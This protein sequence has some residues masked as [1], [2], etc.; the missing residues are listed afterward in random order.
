MADKPAP[1]EPGAVVIAAAVLTL[2]AR[3]RAQYRQWL[4]R[5]TDYT[6]ASFCRPNKS[7]ASRRSE[8]RASNASARRRMVNPEGTDRERPLHTKLMVDHMRDDQPIAKPFSLQ[9]RKRVIGETIS[10]VPLIYTDPVIVGHHVDAVGP[11]KQSV[12]SASGILM[13]IAGK[14]CLVV[15]DHVLRAYEQ[16]AAKDHTVFQFASCVFNPLDRLVA[17]SAKSDIAIVGLTGLSPKREDE[18]T[19]T[20]LGLTVSHR[21]IRPMPPLQ[22]Y[23]PSSWP[24][25]PVAP[26]DVLF[27]SGFP[28]VYRTELDAGHTL[29]HA[30]LSI[31]GVLVTSVSEYPDAFMCQYEPA[32]LEVAIPP[33][34]GSEFV[35]PADFSG[36]SGCPLFRDPGPAPSITFDLVGFVREG[37]AGWGILNCSASTN[38]H[39]D[40]TLE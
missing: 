13:E 32:E 17:R 6:G 3:E 28:E 15:S 23:R 1:S 25:R 18:I 31:G 4:G 20:T 19:D 12:R 9:T 14:V 22:V 40:G 38:I 36:L 34:D 11:E 33:A 27:L 2:P 30:G 37:S 7:G 21:T 10:Q 39:V 26:D 35:M 24:P 8:P 29:S 5:W 16:F